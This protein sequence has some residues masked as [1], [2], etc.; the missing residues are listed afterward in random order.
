MHA[1]AGWS[2]SLPLT[3]DDALLIQQ[4]FILRKVQTSSR[5]W[6]Q[7]VDTEGYAQE[8]LAYVLARLHRFDPDRGPAGLFISRLVD[9]QLAVIRR[10]HLRRKDRP[11][12]GENGD[13]LP[14]LRVVPGHDNDDLAID[15][16]QVLA[17]L[18]PEERNLC[19][20][21]SE[22][23]NTRVAEQCDVSRSTLYRRLRVIRQRCEDQGLAEY[24]K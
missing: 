14:G 7:P 4:R 13:V 23:S 8:L 12:G 3:D 15:L 6:P 24:L 10:K 19:Q 22:Q 21:V 16:R 11:R 18:T 20:W 1:L 5:Y 17:T 9:Q 2:P